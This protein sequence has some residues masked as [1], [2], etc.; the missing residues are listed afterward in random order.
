MR[1]SHVIIDSDGERGYGDDVACEFV[2]STATVNS[3]HW[4]VIE[5]DP[6][7]D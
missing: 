4:E 1:G 2:A 7:R 5:H 6:A 3:L